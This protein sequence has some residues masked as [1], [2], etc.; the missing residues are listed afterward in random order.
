MLLCSLF[1]PSH[2]FSRTTTPT[3]KYDTSTPFHVCSSQ[4]T[5]TTTHRT[6]TTFYPTPS[7]FS[8][9]AIN[10]IP[11]A[12][13]KMP[14]SNNVE[15]SAFYHE[16]SNRLTEYRGPYEDDTNKR[17][18]RYIESFTGKRFAVAVEVM[19]SFN[20]DVY[21]FVKIECCLDGRS[22]H[23]RCMGKQRISGSTST[24]ERQTWFHS[25]S[26]FVDGQWAECAFTFGDLLK[27][28]Y[29]SMPTVAEGI[30]TN[31]AQVRASSTPRRS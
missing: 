5:L 30:P 16:E 25:A 23:T 18:Y 7:L 19:K 28:M 12:T 4:Y 8:Y 13:A 10:T 3:D 29:P 31:N 6:N 9:P 17:V 22:T 24:Q 1:K 2:P 20:F 27:G 14:V 21:P 15:V 11:N 26:R